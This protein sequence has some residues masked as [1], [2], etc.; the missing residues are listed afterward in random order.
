VSVIVQNC[1]FLQNNSYVGFYHFNL[2]S[3]AH[4]KVLRQ[5]W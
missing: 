4:F 2:E 3:I 5:F 1:K